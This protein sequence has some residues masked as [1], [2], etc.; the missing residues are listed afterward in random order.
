MAVEIERKF[1]IDPLSLGSLPTGHVIKQGYIATADRTTVRIRVREQQAYLTIKGPTTGLSRQEFEYPIPVD[2]ALMM[3][4]SLC[5]KPLIEKTRHLIEYAGHCWEVDVFCGD[6]EGLI[7][8]EVELKSEDEAVNLPLWITQE[9]T[10]DRRYYNSSL[11]RFPYCQWPD[12][13]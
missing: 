8:A 1:L 5:Q 2:D 11:M 7:V 12:E 6:N 13:P 4:N 9:V 3:L 10:G